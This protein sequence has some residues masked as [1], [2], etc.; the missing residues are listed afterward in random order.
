MAPAT[1]PR[2]RSDAAVAFVLAVLSAAVAAGWIAVARMDMTGDAYIYA[3]AAG[4]M[5]RG[6]GFLVNGLH[7]AFWNPGYSFTLVPLFAAFGQSP[8]T[9]AGLN[10]ALHALSGVLVYLLARRL[11]P[12]QSAAIIVTLPV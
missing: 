4:N 8:L 7:T 9:V 2:V 5:L 1:T 6:A 10:I 12:S 3:E 11:L